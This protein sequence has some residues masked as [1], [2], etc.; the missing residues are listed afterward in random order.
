MPDQAVTLESATKDITQTLWT[1]DNEGTDSPYWLL[2]DPGFLIERLTPGVNEEGE[3]YSFDVTDESAVEKLGEDIP[4]MIT[5]PF[6]SRADAGEYLK[7]RRYEYSSHA[8]IW[9]ASGYWS[10]KYKTFC[11]QIG[12]GKNPEAQ[13]HAGF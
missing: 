12:V 1:V 6:F 8:Y 3:E 13:K 11:R 10:D 7:R 4:H 2:I 5:G 9:C